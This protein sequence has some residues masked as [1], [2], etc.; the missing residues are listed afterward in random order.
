M[1]IS[2]TIESLRWRYAVKK[3]KP[4]NTLSDEQR[5]LVQEALRLSASSFGVQPWRF[6]FVSDPAMKAKFYDAAWK[7]SQAR[8]CASLVVLARPLTCTAKDVERYIETMSV[9]REVPRES[10]SGLESAIKGF[11][12]G[13][14]DEQCAT[15]MENQVYIALGT[16]L[17]VC[18]QHRID[19]CPM[20][21]FDKDK[22]D[23][24]LGL[25]EQGLRSVVLC[26][27]GTR[28]DDDKYSTQKKVRFATADVIRF[29]H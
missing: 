26:A 18:A 8:D 11:V 23:E 17:T 4:S 10:L 22:V 7:Q 29:Y 5:E 16:L 12:S 9:T 3:F 19:T 27:L 21:G 20:G 2:E 13:M 1:T 6:F 28:A 14:N 25:K 15:W 24:L